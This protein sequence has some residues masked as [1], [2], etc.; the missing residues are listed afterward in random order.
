MLQQKPSTNA[1]LVQELEALARLSQE[2]FSHMLAEQ[3]TLAIVSPLP[4]SKLRPAVA[5]AF[6]GLNA[7]AP[8]V[9]WP[10]R[11]LAA[12][13]DPLPSTGQVP[14]CFVV[15]SRENP[16]I[17]LTLVF[18]GT[19]LK[20]YWNHIGTIL[21]PYWNHIGTNFN[22]VQLQ[23][24]A[25]GPMGQVF[26]TGALWPP[27]SSV[28]WLRYGAGATSATPRAARNAMPCGRRWMRRHHGWGNQLDGHSRCWFVVDVVT[29]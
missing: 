12:M 6:Q 8:P 28:S 15:Q 4:S 22:K 25:M 13:A 10:G 16:G 17:S 27:L 11:R 29:Q 18:V 9:T 5:D 20:P 3:S 19:I 14:P 26:R 2:L 21:E 24:L 1:K 23:P 7:V